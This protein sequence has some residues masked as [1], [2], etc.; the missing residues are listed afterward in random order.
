MAIIDCL[1]RLT[2]IR[3]PETG[4]PSYLT[5]NANSYD[6]N[7]VDGYIEWR[8]EDNIQLDGPSTQRF[9]QTCVGIMHMKALVG[10]SGFGGDARLDGYIFSIYS[11]DDELVARMDMQDGFTRFEAHGDTIERTTNV[12]QGVS[13]TYA[14][15]V[16]KVDVNASTIEVEWWKAGISQGTAS[17]ANTVGGKGRPAYII[18]DIFDCGFSTAFDGRFSVSEVIVTDGN[19]NPIGYRVAALNP[20]AV[21]HYDEFDGVLAD[22][23]NDSDADARVATETGQR[24][25]FDVEAYGGSTSGFE[26]LAVV[27]KTAAESATGQANLFNFCRIGTTDYD[28]VAKSVEGGQNV[29]DIRS[30]N[31]ATGVAWAFADLATTEWG[32]GSV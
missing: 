4:S 3:K 1:N 26:I 11:E 19:E 31:P 24:I 9:S 6:S 27:Q 30:V 32:A 12:N 20:S 29:W 22:M 14:E 13:R 23:N 18:W 21:G 8:T 28:G 2:E 17:A 15:W 10:M 5:A 16:V 7:Y 25:S